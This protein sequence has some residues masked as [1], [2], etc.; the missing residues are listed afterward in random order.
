MNSHSFFSRLCRSS[1]PK[2]TAVILV[3]L[4][5]SNFNCGCSTHTYEAVVEE[6]H[7][8]ELEKDKALISNPDFVFSKN[9]FGVTPLHRAAEGGYKDVVELLLAHRADVNAKDNDGDTPLALAAWD[10][11]I[12]V[13]VTKILL[14]HGADVNAKDNN[15]QTPVQIAQAS[16]NSYVAELLGGSAVGYLSDIARHYTLYI[17]PAGG[18]IDRFMTAALSNALELY[19]NKQMAEDYLNCGCSSPSGSLNDAARSWAKSH[20]YVLEY[21]QGSP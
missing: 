16:N 20:N 19:G 12:Y 5:W 7:K 6:Q 17:H 14:A 15:G 13:D 21:S 9:E 1:I 18:V 11:Y 3:A 8:D 10:P 2:R 4:A